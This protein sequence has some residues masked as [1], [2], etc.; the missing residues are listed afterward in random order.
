MPN[1]S[2]TTSRSPHAAGADAWLPWMRAAARL[3][4]RGHGLVEPNPMVGCVVLDAR[5]ALAGWGLHRRLGGPHAEVEALR[6]AGTKARGGTAV[7]TLEPCAHVGR[8]PPC[9]DALRHAGVARV[10]H[11]GADPN[12]QAAGG[13]ERLR[14]DG[15]EVIELA[16]RETAELNAPF[17]KRVRTGL[18]WVIAKWAQTIDGCVATRSHDSKW[19]SGERSRRMVHRERGRVDAILTGIGTVMHDDP[20]LT[21]RGVR[22]RRDAIR[23]VID[24]RLELPLTAAL[25]RT[26]RTHRTVVATLPSSFAERSEHR[27]ALGDLGVGC[28]KQHSDLRGLLA[29]LRKEYGV[30]TVLVEAGGGLT[31]ALL[32]ESLIDEAWVFVGPRV[33]GDAAAM[34]PARGLSPLSLRDAVSA[35]LLSARRRDGDALLHYRFDGAS[36]AGSSGNAIAAG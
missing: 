22:R 14:G 31:G 12:P 18:P 15:V 36:A 32:K 30:H 11:G 25:A 9:V 17:F 34:H 1:T 8:T 6:R 16:C 4:V 3:A 2:S 28:M 20:Q 5:G 35:R 24:P 10:V 7:V 21:A 13:G 26:A 23:V 27:R 29:S 33:V 19:I